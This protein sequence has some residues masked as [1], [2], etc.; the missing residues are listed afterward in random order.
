MSIKHK[1]YI[2][3]S[4]SKQNQIMQ[5]K[6][7]KRESRE[8][9]Y[10]IMFIII[11]AAFFIFFILGIVSNRLSVLVKDPKQTVIL[12]TDVCKDELI[13]RY[14]LAVQSKTLEEYNNGL[15]AIVSEVESFADHQDDP[16]CSFI[17]YIYYSQKVDVIKAR[18]Y[19]NAIKDQSNLGNYFNANII[20][21]N[22]IQ[23][24][25][26]NIKSLENGGSNNSSGGAG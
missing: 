11:F 8:K 25:E 2:E 12:H 5:N 18:Q 15:G 17:L 6:L 19:V 9:P 21:L 14:N 13:D 4:E 26:N 3:V 10:I 7:E 24:I 23:N 22:S 16:S 20:N 1:E